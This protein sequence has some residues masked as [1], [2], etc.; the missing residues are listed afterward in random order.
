MFTVF[1]AADAIAGP[2]TSAA[3]TVIV[4][5]AMARTMTKPPVRGESRRQTYL[6]C[7]ADC[8]PWASSTT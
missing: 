7:G 3:A 8:K 1:V 4:T 5:A 6:S 2:A